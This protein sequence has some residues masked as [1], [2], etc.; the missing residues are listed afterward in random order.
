MNYYPAAKKINYFNKTILHSMAEADVRAIIKNFTDDSIKIFEAD[1]GF[2]RGKFGIDTKKSIVYVSKNMPCE[3]V[4]PQR[5]EENNILFDNNVKL[6]D[7]N[8]EIC[9]FIKSYLI[10]PIRYVDHVYGNIVL[11]YKKQHNFTEEELALSST[12]GNTIAQSITIN[13][14][15]EKEQKDLALAEKQKETETLLTQEKLK[16]EFIANAT[17]ELRTP[18]AI[19]KAEVDLALM[20]KKI[21]SAHI[22]LRTVNAEIKILAEILKDLAL[23]TS[24]DKG[25]KEEMLKEDIDLIRVIELSKKRLEN[26]ASGKK[27]KISLDT[28]KIQRVNIV[29]DES[30]LEK[31]FLNVIRNAVTYGKEGGKIEINISK[32]KDFVKIKVIDDGIGI[33]R[34]DLPKI[35]ERFYQVDKA[36]SSHGTHSGL[37]LAIAKWAAD[38]HGGSI[39]VKSTPGVGSTFTVSLPLAQETVKKKLHA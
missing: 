32:E 9:Q 22:A 27:I 21:D 29:G 6:E 39:D 16:T 4:L 12:L 37:G 30:Y 38:T 3:P 5:K 25:G 19:M 26:L 31:L 20:D 28:K 23:L 36:H 35:F 10:I 33:S 18:L 34:E 11:C 15:V 1:F 14:L 8:G 17:H 7:Y 2:A 13:W 24:K